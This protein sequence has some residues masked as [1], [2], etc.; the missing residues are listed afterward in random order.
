MLFFI[1]ESIGWQELFLIGVLALIFFGPR[2]LPQIARTVGKAM[3][4]LRRAGQ[5]FK[6]TWENELA[7][8]E[9]EKRFWRDPFDENLILAEEKYSRVERQEKLEKL[10]AG[11]FF[12][13]QENSKDS[14][15]SGIFVKEVGK[16]K[17]DK[18]KTRLEESLEETQV[19][20]ANEKQNWL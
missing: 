1:G 2:K 15:S 8:E 6:K 9:E 17:I 18:R 16:T 14:A 5:E 12:G 4:E 13:N 11:I 7:I 10:E 3:T 20:V 19:D